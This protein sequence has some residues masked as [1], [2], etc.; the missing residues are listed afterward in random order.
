M[1]LH[2]FAWW[3]PRLG[4]Q[5]QHVYP[6]PASLVTQI[7]DEHKI[8]QNILG[9][10]WINITKHWRINSKIKNLRGAQ[11]FTDLW[12]NKIVYIYIYI[13]VIMCVSIYLYISLDIDP[14]CFVQVVRWIWSLC[15][16]HMY[17]CIHFDSIIY[18]GQWFHVVSLYSTSVPAPVMDMIFYVFHRPMYINVLWEG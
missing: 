5:G 7:Q 17:L 18:M 16:I 11:I 8:Y 2:V 13:C 14:E 15:N 9:S 10:A 3:S 4:L 1:T 12:I 6:D